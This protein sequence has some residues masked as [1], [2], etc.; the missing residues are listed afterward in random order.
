MA[1]TSLPAYDATVP[2]NVG[3]IAVRNTKAGLPTGI[4]VPAGRWTLSPLS[5]IPFAKLELPAPWGTRHLTWG[6]TVEVPVLDGGAQ[7]PLSNDSYHDGDIILISQGTGW[8]WRGNPPN[9]ISVVTQWSPMQGQPA[10][11]LVTGWIDTRR[12]RRVYL[13]N[14][15]V[16][17]DFTYTVQL[18]QPTGP[19]PVVQATDAR[20]L[21][22]DQIVRGYR[23]LIPCGYLS[24]ENQEPAPG[25]NTLAELRPMLLLDRLRVVFPAGQGEQVNITINTNAWFVL[26]Y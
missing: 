20:T 2:W 6:E 21:Q 17:E 10:G 1:D 12:A 7:A 8:G 5:S 14:N 25:I 24:G 26:E 11:T 19:G 23:G 15:D 16:G 13:A 18:Q 4:S 3:E 22:F 9:C